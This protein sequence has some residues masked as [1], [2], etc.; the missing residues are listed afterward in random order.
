M[1]YSTKFFFSAARRSTATLAAAEWSAAVTDR[2][3]AFI[4]SKRPQRGPHPKTIRG[5]RLLPHTISS[6]QRLHLCILQSLF[7]TCST[8]VWAPKS[9]GNH[10]VER[11]RKTTRT[12]IIGVLHLLSTYAYKNVHSS[13]GASSSCSSTPG[14]VPEAHLIVAI[15]V[16]IIL[17]CNDSTFRLRCCEVT[18][19]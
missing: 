16:N 3:Q 7:C 8:V 4:P 18:S 13:L 5:R 17:A 15:N 9:P 10:T 14:V 2:S 12:T 1:R 19:W 6:S 11:N